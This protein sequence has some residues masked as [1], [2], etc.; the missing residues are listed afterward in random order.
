MTRRN[1]I[2]PNR[3]DLVGVRERLW[4]LE[5]PD[6]PEDAVLALTRDDTE[7]LAFSSAADRDQHHVYG[8]PY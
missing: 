1:A 2:P 8:E 7:L 5:R 6:G 4:L 3:G